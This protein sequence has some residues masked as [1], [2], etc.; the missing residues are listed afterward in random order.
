MSKVDRREFAKTAALAAVASA[1]AS[2][3]GSAA[4]TPPAPPATKSSGP[5]QTK[6]M[7]FDPSKVKGI[8][9]KLLTSHYE[10]N[11][12]GA[13]KRLNAITGQLA[14]LDWATAPNFMINGLKREE[15]IAM[16]SMI[17]H[18]HYFN[19][20]GGAGADPTGPLAQAIIRD[21][22]GMDRWR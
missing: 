3:V 1:A 16:N 7:P 17:L 4:E 2:S 22:G 13:V 18:E 14:S 15:L 8:S 12:T 20:L 9:E 21:F 19:A 10:N 11:Y 6:P 5:Y